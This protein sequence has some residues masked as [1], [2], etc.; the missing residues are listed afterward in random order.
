[1]ATL[2]ALIATQ[3]VT[4]AG[5][6]AALKAALEDIVVMGVLTGDR[7]G[8]LEQLEPYLE[9]AVGTDLHLFFDKQRGAGDVVRESATVS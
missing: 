3:A 4:V 6:R 1:M 8:H 7:I 2:S 9:A 5:Q